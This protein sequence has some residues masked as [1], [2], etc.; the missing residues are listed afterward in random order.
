MRA[1]VR[2]YGL[3]TLAAGLCAGL[4][5]GGLRAEAQEAW[6]PADLGANLALWLDG[7]DVSTM[8]TNASGQ[9]SQ[10]QDK[11]GGGN[12]AAQSAAANQPTY[13]AAQFGGRGA[14]MFDGD[15]DHLN[16]TNKGMF[17]NVSGASIAAVA[18]S[19]NTGEARR[20][21]YV[22]IGPNQS[23]N[24]QALMQ[25]SGSA[26]WICQFRRLDGD[27][28]MSQASSQA[29]TAATGVTIAVTD[30]ARNV[31][32]LYENGFETGSSNFAGSGNTSD[33]DSFVAFVGANEGTPQFWQGPVGEIVAVKSALSAADREKLEGYLAHRW[34]TADLLAAYHPYRGSPPVKN[35]PVIVAE[36]GR[37]F[38]RSMVG[39]LLSTGGV[40]TAVWVYWGTDGDRGAS[41]E[42]WAYTNLVAAAPAVTGRYEQAVGGT[43]AGQTVTY[44]Y[45][46]VNAA[47]SAW[48]GPRPLA[49]YSMPDAARASRYRAP[50]QP[51]GYDRSAA[52]TNFPLLVRFAQ[53]HPSGFQYAQ[54]ASA[55]G[56]D[57]RF[58]AEDGA[59]LDAE[60][61]VWNV[62]GESYFWVRVP[63]LTSATVIAA[64]WGNAEL[65]ATLPP[66]WTN[67]AAWNSDYLLVSHD[68]GV[69]DSTSHRR[70][71][72]N[73]DF[74]GWTTNGMA[75]TALYY[76]FNSNKDYLAVGTLGDF[77][78]SFGSDHG[79]TAWLKTDTDIANICGSLNDGA[80]TYY[81]WSI[82][83]YL[84]ASTWNTEPDALAI[85][86]RANG[87]TTLNFDLQSRAAG[88]GVWTND[89]WHQVG[90]AATPSSQSGY[91]VRNGVSRPLTSDRTAFTG[92]TSNFQYPFFIGG[93]NN[94]G[95]PMTVGYRGAIDEFRISLPGRS[96]DWLWADYMTL[97]HNSAFLAYGRVRQGVGTIILLR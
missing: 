25:R 30:Y 52:L 94:R 93:A 34:G 87:G 22:T 80:N 78:S 1:T 26:Q 74:T 45:R 6:T 35:A 56:Y 64:V 76:P 82:N 63:E 27:A 40:E 23:R 39:A 43:A 72:T 2:K 54:A 17:R 12:H 5:A 84:A 97:A 3:R 91:I 46:A 11:S 44:R 55:H 16:L 96:Q 28:N 95:T 4:G 32:A 71:G 68:G 79:I 58:V 36:P 57:I 29:N 31:V 70:H 51:V 90:F 67:G 69:T 92:A 73:P 85:L 53:D 13:S 50:I 88:M 37:R 9:I 77:G 8:T 59:D 89:E 7:Q 41:P 83:R 81:H 10:W 14:A 19:D 38:D 47:G 15:S 18:R 42:D 33:T 66:S 20:L 49:P 86:F 62:N 48:S 75:G 21:V 24:R 65:A 60:R 61:D